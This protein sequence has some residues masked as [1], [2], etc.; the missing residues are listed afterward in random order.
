MK[1]LGFLAFVA[2]GMLLGACSESENVAQEP[3]QVWNK[4]G[5]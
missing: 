2:A 1:K 3:D 5:K 4:E